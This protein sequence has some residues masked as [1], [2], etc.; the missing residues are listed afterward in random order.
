ML[1]LSYNMAQDALSRAFQLC[2][3]GAEDA[4]PLGPLAV[5]LTFVLF[6]LTF[7]SGDC[8]WALAPA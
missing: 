5:A 2:L 4:L 7:L 6:A 3:T 1:V 8:D